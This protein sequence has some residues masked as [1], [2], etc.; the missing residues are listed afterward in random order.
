VKLFVFGLGYTALHFVRRHRGRFGRIA[1][2]VR[3]RDKAV[4]LSAEGLDPRVFSAEERDKR[5]RGDI[6]ASDVLLSSVAPEGRRDPVLDAFESDIAAAPHL[7]WI[8]YLSTIGV[9]GDHAGAWIDE[10]TPPR[11]PDGRSQARLAAEAAW[12]ALGGRTGKPVHIFRLGGIYGPWR[13]ALAQLAAGTARR[14][15][16][17]GQVFNRIHVDDIADVLMASIDR[18]D[19]G[20]VY[21]LVDDEPSPPQDLI[22]YAADLAGVE[23]PPEIPFEAA[24]LSPIAA[25]FYA[26]NR[27]VRNDRLKHQL[28]VS[29]LYPTYREGLR[30]LRA[31]GE[32]P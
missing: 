19:G 7:G 31:A 9:Y 5:I 8:G 10:S 13:N 20:A 29:L 17:P 16:K 27:R 25:S 21:N 14:V 26:E 3:S 11:A 32:G 23:R 6:A 24:D 30:A 12:L 2:T 22:A 15:V 28:G 4:A 18:P 1:G